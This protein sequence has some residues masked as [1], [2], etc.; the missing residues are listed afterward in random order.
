[1]TVSLL[2]FGF[3]LGLKHAVEA[4][5]VAAVA[6]LASRSSSLKDHVVLA[7]S[8]GIGHAAT[9]VAASAVIVGL[10]LSLPAYAATTVE[11]AVGLMLVALGA[12][13][14]R[15]LRR[16]R[17][18]FHVHRHADRRAHFHA[19]AH[20]T[21]TTHDAAHHEHVHALALR[22]LLV[23]GL[24]GLGG[25]AALALVAVQATRSPGSAVA[26]CGVFGFGTI[27]G[28]MTLSL[29]IAVPLRWSARGLGHF[30]RGLEGAL[31][32]ATIVLGG[33][34]ALQ[35]LVAP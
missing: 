11:T 3:L 33:W 7:G 8:W 15:R 9:I 16:R 2:V 30:Q 26:Y 27:I 20:D 12:D 22:A 24:H 23:G 25:S 1:V 6:T 34:I 5:H 29:V 35:T 31:G 19:H 21:E 32:T 10:G 18:H 17:V 28:M 13:V 4:D 14:L